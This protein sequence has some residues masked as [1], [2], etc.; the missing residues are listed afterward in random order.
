[1]RRDRNHRSTRSRR[2]R[3]GDRGQIHAAQQ[4]HQLLELADEDPESELTRQLFFLMSIGRADLV[5]KMK[6]PLIQRA[7]EREMKGKKFPLLKNP[8]EGELLL[9]VCTDL[10]QDGPEVRLP[11]SFL[12]RHVGIFGSSGGGK[13]HFMKWQAVQLVRLGVIV[14]VFDVEGEYSE[15]L[16]LFPRSQLWWVKPPFPDLC[17]KLNPFEP[18]KGLPPE[19]WIGKIVDLI[20]RVFF[21][22][23]G[24]SMVL[25]SALKDLYHRRGCM[26]GSNNWP[27]LSQVRSHVNTLNYARSPRKAG[28]QETLARCLQTMLDGLGGILNCVQ[29]TP[30]SEITK[31]AFIIDISDLDPLSAEFFESLLILKIVENEK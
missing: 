28:Y 3:T 10:D 4:L 20:R 16:P 2:S 18:P 22:A 6:R 12:T 13:S 23:D 19:V 9:G 17:F 27:S 25:S 26:R 24:G 30:I 14:V 29:G 8:T 21:M 11:L 5:E 31:Q 1:V 7:A 15:I